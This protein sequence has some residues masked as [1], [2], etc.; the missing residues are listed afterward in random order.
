MNL[1]III[2]TF[3]S[4]QFGIYKLV[5]KINEMIAT[6][7]SFFILRNKLKWLLFFERTFLLKDIF[8]M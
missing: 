1:F 2:Y 8:I 4:S 5:S 6:K 7:T 3:K